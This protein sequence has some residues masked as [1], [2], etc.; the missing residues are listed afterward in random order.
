MRNLIF[1]LIIVIC[2]VTSTSE[3]A[4]ETIV[5]TSAVGADASYDQSTEVSSWAKGASGW[6]L[7]SGFGL[8]IFDTV[9]V[10]GAFCGMTNTPLGGDAA[11]A[12]F[13]TGTWSMKLSNSFLTIDIAGEIVGNYVETKDLDNDHIDG[14]AV[15]VVDT[16]TFTSGDWAWEG[17]T[18]TEVGIIVDILLPEDSTFGDYDSDSYNSTNATITLYADETAV[19]EPATMCLLGLGGLLYLKRR[20][21]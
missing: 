16:F 13:N 9:T 10:T 19:P 2:M 21:A 7:T 17:G 14:R 15:V 3:A 20:R 18:D 12:T 11:Q 5:L 4:I 8:V 1:A 6:S